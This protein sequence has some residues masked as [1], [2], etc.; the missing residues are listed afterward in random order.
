MANGKWLMAA[1]VGMMVVLALVISASGAE[2]E[3]MERIKIGKDGRSFILAPSGKAFAPRGFNYDRDNDGRLLEDYW[4][5][6]WPKVQEDFAEMTALGANVVRVHLQ[7]GRFMR[8]PDKADEKALDR[9]DRLVSLAESLNLYLDITGLG[10]YRTEHIPDWYDR[11]SEAERW[12]AQAAFWE[13]IAARCADRPGVFCYDLMNEPVVPSGRR[14]PEE[15][16]GPP[17]AKVYHYVQF[18][19]LDQQDRARPDIARDWL[20]NMKSAIRKHDRRHLITVGML[21]TSGAGFAPKEVARELDFL[22]VHIYPKS[23]KMEESLDTLKEFSVG[24][25]LVIEEV[26]PMHCSVPELGRFLK[27]SEK[28]SVGWIGFYWGKTP[29]QCRESGSLAD[30]LMLGWLEWFQQ[31]TKP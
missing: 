17:F 1:T 21:P 19:A 31:E 25:P 7:F 10:C 13:A 4:E 2:Y 28:Y 14:K 18:I 8:S 15:W 20:R 24:K 27:E 6:E 26:F 30:A 11:L 5:T 16:L 9:L 22:S 29:E 12:R 3:Q 23:S